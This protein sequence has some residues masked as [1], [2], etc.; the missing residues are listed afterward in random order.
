MNERNMD[1]SSDKLSSILLNKQHKYQFQE[2]CFIYWNIHRNIFRNVLIILRQDSILL[3][4]TSD[5]IIG[6]SHSSDFSTDS[7]GLYSVQHASG[8]LVNFNQVDLD[9]SVILGVDDSVA[10]RAEKLNQNKC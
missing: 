3:C 5:A 9:R 4:E 10:G 6:F 1:S 8:S 7:I 2:R